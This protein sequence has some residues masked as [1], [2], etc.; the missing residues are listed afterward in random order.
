[1][2]EE[3]TSLAIFAMVI[4]IG[5]LLLYVTY[6]PIKQ[7]AWSDVKQNKKTHSNGSFGKITCTK[8]ITESEQIVHADKSSYLSS[9]VASEVLGTNK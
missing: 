5:M 4:A 9:T 3:T 6:K 2:M 8:Y 7:W 1:M